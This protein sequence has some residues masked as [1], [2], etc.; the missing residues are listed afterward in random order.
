MAE[1]AWVM[2]SSF[3]PV[4]PPG[5]TPP[6]ELEVRPGD[7]LIFVVG[8]EVLEAL[9]DPVRERLLCAALPDVTSEMPPTPAMLEH[10]WGVVAV[11]VEPC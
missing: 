11:D 9:A 7:R 1:H 5:A 8:H 3:V 2:V 10:G 6:L 4:D